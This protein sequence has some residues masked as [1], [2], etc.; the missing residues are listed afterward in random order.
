VPLCVFGPGRCVRAVAGVCEILF[1]FLLILSGNLSFLNYL[2]IIPAIACIDDL[3]LI[4]LLRLCVSVL[5]KV[6]RWASV[7]ASG[8]VCG[9]C[10]MPL[11]FF[12]RWI[13]ARSRRLIQQYERYLLF[14][15]QEQQQ[16][17][18]SHK[19]N[20]NNNSIN[21][22]TANEKESNNNNNNNNNI[23][24]I[25]KNTNTHNW[26]RR[27][28]NVCHF[29]VLLVILYLTYNGPF[30]V[31]T[32]TCVCVCVCEFLSLSVSLFN[33]AHTTTTYNNSYITHTQKQNKTK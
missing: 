25:I 30:K 4:A 11:V 31:Y 9:L 8:G 20:N 24:T 7:C 27:A 22:E 21:N 10:V 33:N 23:N 2:T 3:I 13:C 17:Q 5:A 28:R 26:K 15:K 14:I 29:V 16:Q 1:Q 6:L 18:H 32:Y 12:L 19:Q